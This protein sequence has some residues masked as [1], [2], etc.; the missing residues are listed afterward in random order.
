MNILIF[1]GTLSAFVASFSHS[2]KLMHTE[3]QQL[4]L[5]LYQLMSQSTTS[6]FQRVSPASPRAVVDDAKQPNITPVP[7][8]LSGE[9]EPPSI[10][11]NATE[12]DKTGEPVSP[13][14]QPVTASTRE[15][16]MTFLDA[17]DGYKKKKQ[18]VDRLKLQLR[19]HYKEYE[20]IIDAK[21]GAEST[22]EV[23]ADRIKRKTE[24]LNRL[25]V[26]YETK[27]AS[28]KKFIETYG[29]VLSKYSVLKINLRLA[30]EGVAKYTK[31]MDECRPDVVEAFSSVFEAITGKRK[32]DDAEPEQDEPEPKRRKPEPEKSSD[33]PIHL[34]DDT[35]E[36][37]VQSV[38]K[39]PES[40][41][42][43]EVTAEPATPSNNIGPLGGHKRIPK[44]SKEELSTTQVSR[45]WKVIP[46]GRGYVYIMDLANGRRVRCKK[47]AVPFCHLRPDM[48]KTASNRNK[49]KDQ[50]AA[51]STG[52]GGV[53]DEA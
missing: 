22:L 43:N 41:T 1:I 52:S 25:K 46:V 39:R 6:A 32:A 51:S 23:M 4:R 14:I 7:M 48:E 50:G 30:R 5:R 33:F 9:A 31:S 11:L 53:G 38:D 10:A 21:E 17:Q 19:S 12:V 15:R 18:T 27:V 49:T 40:K 34:L 45:V 8:E 35:D 3:I 47:S 36:E 2:P 37:G 20:S 28:N 44:I 16:V 13:P 29:E 26:E 24:R 42:T